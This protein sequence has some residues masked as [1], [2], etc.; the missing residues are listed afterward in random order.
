MRITEKGKDNGQRLD[1]A[2]KRESDQEQKG[3][4]TKVEDKLRNK[5]Q[6]KRHVRKDTTR[7]DRAEGG[8]IAKRG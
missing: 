8:G 3:R 1:G 7:K 6:G 5:K 2:G 4:R